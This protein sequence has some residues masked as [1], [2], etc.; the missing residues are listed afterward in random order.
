MCKTTAYSAACCAGGTDHPANSMY[1]ALI[2]PE[3]HPEVATHVTRVNPQMLEVLQT[4]SRFVPIRYC[5]NVED[6]IIATMKQ[7]CKACFGETDSDDIRQE[8]IDFIFSITNDPSRMA[9]TGIY[10]YAEG[11]METRKALIGK[12]CRKLKKEYPGLV[13]YLLT[14]LH[15]APVKIFFPWDYYEEIERR[16]DNWQDG[17]DIND[18]LTKFDLRKI[19][20]DYCFPTKKDEIY[21]GAMPDELRNAVAL[22]QEWIERG[23]CIQCIEEYFDLPAVWL[24]WDRTDDHVTE[25][26]ID[27]MLEYANECGEALVSPKLLRFEPENIRIFLRGY[28]GAMQ[29]LHYL[30]PQFSGKERR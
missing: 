5:G 30:D 10:F 24:Q 28:L 22:L 6:T 16:L 17:D 26:I 19:F 13:G 27:D 23:T 20:P 21:T 7:Y 11:P 8:T 9:G 4:L 25:R 14:L 2:L 18:Y 15:S 3:L 12:Q 1:T 29:I